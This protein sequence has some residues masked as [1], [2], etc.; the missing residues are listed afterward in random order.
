MQPSLCVAA[1]AATTS[2]IFQPTTTPSVLQPGQKATFNPA[3]MPNIDRHDPTHLIPSKAISLHYQTN[4]TTAANPKVN[5]THT[6][7]YPSVLLE[8]IASVTNVHC[9]ANSVAV[10]F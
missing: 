1:L 9:S 6:M 7:K 5:V 3:P 2:S 4:S 10:T 8:Q